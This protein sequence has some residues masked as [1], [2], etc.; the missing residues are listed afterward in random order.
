M[1]LLVR[2]VDT[3]TDSTGIYWL[4]HRGLDA[5]QG[6]MWGTRAFLLGP[7]VKISKPILSGLGYSTFTAE[8]LSEARYSRVL[9]SARRQNF[10]VVSQT[11]ICST[12]SLSEDRTM[13]ESSSV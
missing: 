13:T 9:L 5:T 10:S 1:V 8:Y 4:P 6:F 2:K 11:A 12:E 7:L 3:D